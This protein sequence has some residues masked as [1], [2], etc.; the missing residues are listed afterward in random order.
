METIEELRGFLTAATQPGAW[1]QLTSR[2]TAWSL[3]R[4]NGVLPA[5]APPLGATIETDLAEHGFAVLRASLALR[6]REGSTPL[7]GQGFYRAATVF[8]AVARNAN[9]ED[10]ELGFLRTLAAAA[11]HLAGYSAVAYSLFSEAP[12]DLNFAP[13]EVAIKLLILRDLD[14]LRTYIREWLAG[15]GVDDQAVAA[16]LADADDADLD[17]SLAIILNGAICRALASGR[18]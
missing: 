6:S 5:D 3:M 11:Y 4:V 8:E 10:K 15:E 1:G 18:R 14:R 13:G 17:E 16:A 7:S 9:P 2:G 12:D